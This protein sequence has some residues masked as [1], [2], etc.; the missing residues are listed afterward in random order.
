MHLPTYLGMQEHAE[1]T[2]GAAF[3]SVAEARE[4]ESD[5]AVLAERMAGQCT[6]H[7]ARLRPAVERYGKHDDEEPERLR[8][9]EFSGERAG[10]LGLLRDLHDLYVLAHFVDITW[11]VV[12]QTAQGLRDEMLLDIV[13]ECQDETAQQVRW[14]TTRIKAAAPQAL[15][16][17]R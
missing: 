2:L 7:A 16:V 13:A 6:A 14:L 8:V 12:Q 9:S 1:R 15:L 10:G 17:A 11:T 5:I 4:A 3:A